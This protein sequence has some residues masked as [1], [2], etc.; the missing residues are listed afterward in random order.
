MQLLE[1]EA[2]H[3][4]KKNGSSANADAIATDSTISSKRQIEDAPDDALEEDIEAK[5]QRVLEETRDIDADSDGSP[6]ESSEA[7]RSAFRLPSEFL[8]DEAKFPQ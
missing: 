1:A 3:F 8:K 5:R 4:G 6:S 7:D 2:A